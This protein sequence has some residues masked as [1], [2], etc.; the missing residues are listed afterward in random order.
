MDVYPERFYSTSWQ[1]AA[2]SARRVVPLVIDYLAPRSVVDV[3]CGVAAWLEVLREAG[4]ADVLGVD[5]PHINT[6]LLRIPAGLF[7][8]H[9]LS[10][11]LQLPRGFDLAMSLEVA[12]HLPA[13][14]AGRFVRDLTRLAPVVM[15]SAAVPGQGGT[16]HVNEQWPDYWAALFDA[17]GYVVVD[18]L[19]PRIWR[20][21]DVEFFYAQNLLLFVAA[22]ALD[23]YPLLKREEERRRGEPLSLVHPTRWLEALDP[24]RQPLSSLLRN[25]G[26][27]LMYRFGGRS[28]HRVAGRP[29]P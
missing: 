20:D 15:F 1:R 29:T 24:R 8:V 19:R 7:A 25:L 3:G 6:Q 12:E 14:E 23:R 5:G 13:A 21:E 28:V 26:V 17:N 10:G 2:R 27:A 16:H 18:C 9:D 22:D 4:V 11:P